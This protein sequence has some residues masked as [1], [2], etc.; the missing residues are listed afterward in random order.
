M[1][2]FF[3]LS[4]LFLF[5]LFGYA[6]VD[7]GVKTVMVNSNASG[8]WQAISNDTI[9][10]GDTV[11]LAV[12]FKNFG[13]NII[14]SGDSLAFG[15]SVNGIPVGVFGGRTDNFV[16]GSAPNDTDVIVVTDQYVFSTTFTNAI[17]CAW[18]VFWSGGGFGGSTANDTACHTYKV[19]KKV[20]TVKNFTPTEGEVGTDVTIHGSYFGKDA[21]SNV[22]KFGG[23]TA[24]IKSATNTKIVA[25]VPATGVTGSVTVESDGL[26]GTSTEPFT[27]KD[28]DGN[29]V[30]PVSISEIKQVSSF[31]GINN[32]VLYM[33]SGRISQ[34]LRIIDLTGKEVIV[35][36]DIPLNSEY[37]IDLNSLQ[38][39]VYIATYGSEYIKFSK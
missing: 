32:G 23:E 11:Q 1:K 8:S 9:I 39:G 19:W 21:A 10:V 34:D 13:G 29:V 28:A 20:I 7:G 12:V 24:T 16:T 14:N 38:P 2:R 26:T 36:T 33:N 4:S 15:F 25:T 6:Q 27:V 3:L 31:V 5:T 17:V 35:N 22:V 30:Y 37:T 18:P